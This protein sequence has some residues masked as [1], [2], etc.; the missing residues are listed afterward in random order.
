MSDSQTEVKFI[1]KFR[2]E[3]EGQNLLSCFFKSVSFEYVKQEIKFEYY[4]VVDYNPLGD[5]QIWISKIRNNELPEE[6]LTFT[7]YDEDGSPLCQTSFHGLTI[8]SHAAE[9][10]YAIEDISS[11]LVVVSYNNE[12]VRM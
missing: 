2:W 1:K 7:N 9:F 4:N 3:M 10:D 5:I 8:L 12:V 6:T 11:C